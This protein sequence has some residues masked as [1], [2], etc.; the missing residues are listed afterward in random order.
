MS[1]MILLMI[2]F[3]AAVLESASIQT[4][5]NIRRADVERAVE[6]VFAEYQKE[7]LE[8]YDIFGL[9]GTYETGEYSE[10]NVLERMAVFGAVSEEGTMKAV[11]FLSDDEGSGFAEQVCHYMEQQYGLDELEDIFGNEEHAIEQEREAEEYQKKEREVEEEIDTILASQNVPVEEGEDVQDNPLEK[12]QSLKGK[13]LTEISLP[14]GRRISQKSMEGIPGVS[15]RERRT[16]R[17]AFPATAENEMEKLYLISYSSEHFGSYLQSWEDHPLEY[18]REYLIGGKSDDVSNLQIVLDKIRKLRMV[19]NYLYLQSDET[20]KAEAK[21]L[22]GV[23]STVMGNPEL[24][25]A[26]CEGILMMWAYGESIMDLRALAAG[27]K[28]PAVKGK[29][30]WKLSLSGLL[31]L[32]TKEDGGD[33]QKEEEGLGYEEYLNILL[34]LESKEVLRMRMLDLIEWNMRLRLECPF[35]QADACITKVRI[36][37]LCHLRRG[38]TY[39]FSTY[40]AYQ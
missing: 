33:S 35:F 13:L 12:L 27:G 7:L 17:G 39:R 5:K 40:Y 11:R 4:A 18:E 36:E 9:D 15:S 1:L 38:I 16:G 37:S 8:E 34:F 32:G 21:V 28:I 29:D 25:D 22:A 26:V 19:P 24:T 6:S 10:D 14:G 31:Q 30:T 23:I 2:S 3:A 20:K